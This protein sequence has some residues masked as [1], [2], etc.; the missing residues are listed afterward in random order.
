VESNGA[1]VK[2]HLHD[3]YKLTLRI[4]LMVLVRVISTIEMLVSLF[5]VMFRCRPGYCLSKPNQ[6]FYFHWWHNM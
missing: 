4:W 1:E 2:T 5:Y 6:A 3:L